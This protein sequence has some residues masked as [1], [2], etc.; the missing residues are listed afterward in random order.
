MKFS[1]NVKLYFANILGPCCLDSCFKKKEKL[2]TMFE[3]GQD[4]IDTEL[5]IIK[6]TKTLRDIKIFLKNTFLAESSI[7]FAVKHSKK[8]V[9]NLDESEMYFDQ[10]NNALEGLKDRM[11]NK[12]RP[13][14]MNLMN[15]NYIERTAFTDF[16][17]ANEQML[18]L[19]KAQIN[20]QTKNIDTLRKESAGRGKEFSR[21]SHVSS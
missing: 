16:H 2:Q 15:N 7:K 13:S 1:D 4:M 6:L 19:L 5:D 10:K 20:E 18:D 9:I 14:A 21:K 17:T 12:P 11:M 8:N 3:G